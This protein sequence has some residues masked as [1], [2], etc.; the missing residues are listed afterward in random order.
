MENY[1]RKSSK[2]QTRITIRDWTK[3]IWKNDSIFKAVQQAQLLQRK[4][5]NYFLR[6][7][8][9][10]KWDVHLKPIALTLHGNILK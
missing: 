4:N 9:K 1:L 7:I 5:T 3:F 8:W 10:A 2:I 6:E